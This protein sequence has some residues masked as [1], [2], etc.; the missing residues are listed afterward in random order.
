MD[1]ADIQGKLLAYFNQLSPEARDRLLAS[2]PAQEA[3]PQPASG[4]G[5][6]QPGQTLPTKA[7]PPVV[8]GQAQ[9]QSPESDSTP[10]SAPD[11]SASSLLADEL[12]DLK[13]SAS[14]RRGQKAKA[15]TRKDWDFIDPAQ[16]LSWSPDQIRRA[17]G[18]GRVIPSLVFKK[19]GVKVPEALVKHIANT[20]PS[21]EAETSPSAQPG[22]LPSVSETRPAWADIQEDEALNKPLPISSDSPVIEEVIGFG[23]VP[24]HAQDCQPMATQAAQSTCARRITGAAS[25][26][27]QEYPAQ[28]GAELALGAHQQG[29]A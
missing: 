4:S 3:Q 11:A 24:C 20:L 22:P 21:T 2:A 6:A 5:N 28:P 10:N 19:D 17:H 27:C 9:A 8:T 1:T 26:S 15:L 7:P 29:C 23:G 18:D 25:P 14:T 13:K 16:S 12:A